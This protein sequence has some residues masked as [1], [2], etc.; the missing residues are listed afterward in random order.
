MIKKYFLVIV[1]SFILSG[2]NLAIG[3][4]DSSVEDETTSAATS[5]STPVATSESTPVA[6]S[7]STPVATPESTPVATPESTPVATPESTPKSTPESTPE[8]TSVGT[9]VATPETLPETT[10][11]PL[12]QNGDFESGDLMGWIGACAINSPS[13]HSGLFGAQIS[14]SG[15]ISQT[16]LGLPCNTDY[17]L[18]V[19][20][21]FENA[22]GEGSVIVENYLGV[23]IE[24]PM[25]RGNTEWNR[26]TIPFTTRIDSTMVTITFSC[27][28]ANVNVDDITLELVNMD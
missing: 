1:V 6:T 5:E 24:V 25:M 27:T 9:P 15:S 16:I 8:S 3:L 13:A 28:L 11:D 17:I 14:T 21:Q 10:P 4:I 7:E 18:S 12:I 19:Y 20:T 23:E 26:I 22:I 2:C